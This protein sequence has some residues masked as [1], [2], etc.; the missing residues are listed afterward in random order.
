MIRP[1][2][3]PPYLGDPI[4]VVVPY[5]RAQ[6]LAGLVRGLTNDE[7]GLMND[8]SLPLTG[9][10]LEIHRRIRA[11]QTV[12]HITEVGRYKRSWSR[13]DVLAVAWRVQQQ[14]WAQEIEDDRIAA[15]EHV[16][17]TSRPDCGSPNGAQKHVRNHERLCEP[18]RLAR[19]EYQTKRRRKTAGDA[20]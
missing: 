1:W 5:R 14:R 13:A 18:C 8:P 20:A 9:T 7:I 2:V 11:G 6:I 4:P 16:R 12:D 17:A 15:M 19:N 3:P 10:D